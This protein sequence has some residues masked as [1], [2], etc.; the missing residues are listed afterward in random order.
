MRASQRKCSEYITSNEKG[1]K[2]HVAET[3]QIRYYEQLFSKY[4]K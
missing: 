3:K 1:D 4:V 2:S